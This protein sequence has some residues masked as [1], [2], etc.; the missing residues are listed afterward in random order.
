MRPAAGHD[1]SARSRA[2]RLERRISVQQCQRHPLQHRAHKFRL[3]VFSRQPVEHAARMGI[4]AG[5]R[6][7]TSAGTNVNPFAPGSTA[8]ADSSI[9][10]RSPAER[11]PTTRSKAQLSA[12]PAASGPPNTYQPAAPLIGSSAEQNVYTRPAV[13][14]VASCCGHTI[15]PPV[16][17]VTSR[18]SGDVAAAHNTL[19]AV[20]AAPFT[21]GS[22]RGRP[23]ASA[24]AG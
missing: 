2:Q 13:S 5:V 21:T 18:V 23:S 9:A 1:R 12:N 20:S 7:P 3:T 10:S 4:T 15:C 11:T 16:L 14:I 24:A 19:H 6:S 8:P 22:P 17:S